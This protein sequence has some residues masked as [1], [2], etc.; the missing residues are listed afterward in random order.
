MP[1]LSW[2]TL[3]KLRQKD[4]TK[5][6]YDIRSNVAEFN[7]AQR[8]TTFATTFQLDVDRDKQDEAVR[9]LGLDER[10]NDYSDHAILAGVRHWLG[11]QLEVLLD[12]ETLTR[13]LRDPNSAL[14]RCIEQAQARNK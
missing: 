2:A 5:M 12:P 6:N 1:L 8:N 13:E 4:H 14:T 11:L 10:C 9:V 7:L 3:R